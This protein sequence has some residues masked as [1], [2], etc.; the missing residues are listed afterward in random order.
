[1]QNQ[2]SEELRQY[3]DLGIF[4]LS[5]P[6]NATI[7]ASPEYRRRETSAWRAKVDAAPTARDNRRTIISDW[8]DQVYDADHA[9]YL[10]R[11]FRL[12]IGPYSG[13]SYDWMAHAACSEF[14]A[15]ELPER[16][17]APIPTVSRSEPFE[18]TEGKHQ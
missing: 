7:V 3:Q 13:N 17:L 15:V 1:M 18:P 10:F 6:D 8:L 9:I 16:F 2:Y 4:D 14:G 12:H 5:D 11:L